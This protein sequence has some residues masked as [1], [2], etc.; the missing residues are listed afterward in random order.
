MTYSIVA[1]CER[2]HQLGVAAVTAMPAVGKLVSHAMSNAGAI[3]T[4]ALTNPYYGIDGLGL[5]EQG[6]DAR[7]VLDELLKNDP[8]RQRRQARESPASPRAT[9]PN[10]NPRS[11]SQ[12]DP[13]LEGVEPGQIWPN[14][15]KSSDQA[16]LGRPYAAFRPGRGRRT[17]RRTAWFD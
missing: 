1:R 7:S 12:I 9:W 6:R 11:V 16:G 14:S 17:R 3:A 10:S 2:T 8:Q 4:Q 5:L 13:R 15:S